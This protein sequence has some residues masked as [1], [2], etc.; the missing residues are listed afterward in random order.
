V[1]Y[2]EE[3][4]A[5]P[6]QLAALSAELG[7]GIGVDETLRDNTLTDV[8]EAACVLA[9]IL[10]PSTLGSFERVSILAE[11]GALGNKAIVISSALES[12]LGLWHLVQMAAA[13]PGAAVPAGLATETWFAEDLIAPRYDSSAGEMAVAE[14]VGAPAPSIEDA[15]DWRALT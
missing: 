12:G 3:P 10:K 11:R 15:L 9:W 1:E 8:S 13:L 5:D 6:T 7:M 4:L 2:L 14:W